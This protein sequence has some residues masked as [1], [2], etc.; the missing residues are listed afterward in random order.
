MWPQRVVSSFQVYLQGPDR[1]DGFKNKARSVYSLAVPVRVCGPTHNWLG[2]SSPAKWSN[3][4]HYV[5]SLSGKQV[6]SL[7]STRLQLLVLL[8]A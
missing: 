7:A 5:N 8:P 6:P 1:R 3:C 2:P 4:E